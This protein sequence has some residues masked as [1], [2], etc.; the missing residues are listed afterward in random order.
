MRVEATRQI[1]HIV[2][3]AQTLFPKKTLRTDHKKSLELITKR[4]K[5]SQKNIKNPF[6]KIAGSFR[7]TLYHTNLHMS[8]LIS[9]YE[10][11][12]IVSYTRGIT[13]DFIYPPPQR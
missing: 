8:N 2:Q 1:G 5:I 4:Y 9:R 6:Q 7:Q 13:N 3:T 11:F 12:S 10:G